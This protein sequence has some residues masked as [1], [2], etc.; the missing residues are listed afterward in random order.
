MLRTLAD[1]IEE[2]PAAKTAAAARI[3]TMMA[4]DHEYAAMARYFVRIEWRLDVTTAEEQVEP[5]VR[6][7]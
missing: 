1:V 5:P 2:C 3:R 7:P 4:P 6:Q